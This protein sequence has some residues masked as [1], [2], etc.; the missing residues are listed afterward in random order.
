MICFHSSNL[1][2]VF[3][4][5]FV[6]SDIKNCFLR[7]AI[8]HQSV[9]NFFPGLQH[10]NSTRWCNKEKNNECVPLFPTIVSPK[11]QLWH[12]WIYAK[13]A[14]LMSLL[15]Y[16]FSLQ[17]TAKQFAELIMKTTFDSPILPYRHR[18][19]NLYIYAI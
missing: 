5:F 14:S 17:K 7:S 4:S 18:N 12:I 1:F 13:P 15:I 8:N 16:H 3:L 19:F 11:L 9:A 2:T 10:H 6:Y